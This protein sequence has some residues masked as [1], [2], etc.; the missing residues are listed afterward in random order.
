MTNQHA[1]K[2]VVLL[3]GGLDSTTTLAIA[4]DQG[5]V[6]HCLSF[7]YGQRQILELERAAA[8]AKRYGCPHL[9]LRLDLDRIGGSA[10]TDDTPVPK[11]RPLDAMADAIPA[12]Y[13][14]ARNIIFLAH[15]LAWAEVVGARDIFIGANAI[16]YSGYPDC[17]PEFLEAFTR[18]ANLGTKAGLERGFRIQAPLLTLTKAE[19]IKKGLELG[20]DYGSTHTCYDPAP[21]GTACGRCDACLLR[22]RGF[23]E[24]GIDD[25]VAYQS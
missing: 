24:A 13:V 14:P 6:C 22:R 18:M 17:R 11:D 23:A 25:P 2:A 1:P 19:I 9:V 20:V 21:D 8:I 16:D 3:S 10:L 5:Y 4:L 15:A 7:H 12:T